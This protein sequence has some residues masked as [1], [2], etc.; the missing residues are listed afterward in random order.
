MGVNLY[1]T[2]GTVNAKGD[3]KQLSRD[4][5]LMNRCGFGVVGAA[6]FLFSPVRAAPF[7]CRTVCFGVLGCLLAVVAWSDAPR[8]S[9]SPCLWVEAFGSLRGRSVRGWVL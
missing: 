3:L 9:G 6:D 2:C 4:E 5:S 1:D 8:G 7:L